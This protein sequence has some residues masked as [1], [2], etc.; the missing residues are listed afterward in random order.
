[1]YEALERIFDGNLTRYKRIINTNDWL[2]SPI[3]QHEEIS[4]LSKNYVLQPNDN[5]TGNFYYD[6]APK[7]SQEILKEI[8]LNAFKAVGG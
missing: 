2:E 6:Y 5:E 3:E 8:A 4:D 1:M 7:K